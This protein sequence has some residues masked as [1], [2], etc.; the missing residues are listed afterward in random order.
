MTKYREFIRLLSLDELS[1][2][3]IAR[4][5][6]VSRNTVMRVRKRIEETGISWPL[7]SDVTDRELEKLLFLQK[8]SA[9]DKQM[10]DFDYIREELLRNGV[11][12]K[13]LW[14]EYCAECRQHDEQPLM[15][16]QLCYYILNSRISNLCRHYETAL[17]PA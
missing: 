11:N 1:E 17:K 16:S 7:A 4:S 13:L 3:D 14:T 2:R 6:N 5:C 8:K 9:T 10:P 12:K 15:Y